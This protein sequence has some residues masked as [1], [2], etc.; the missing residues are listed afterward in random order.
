MSKSRNYRK[1]NKANSADYSPWKLFFRASK[2]IIV[3]LLIVLL[4][5]CA[6]IIL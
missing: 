1:R 2:I 3:F 6:A 5:V 4:Y